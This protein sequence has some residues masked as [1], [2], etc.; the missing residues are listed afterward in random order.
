MGTHQHNYIAK[1]SSVRYETVGGVRY[2]ITTTFLEC[3]NPGCPDPD[4]MDISRERA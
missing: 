1:R 3:V 4:R 2:R